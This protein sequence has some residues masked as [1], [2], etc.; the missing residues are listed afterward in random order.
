VDE[1]KIERTQS[2]GKEAPPGPGAYHLKYNFVERKGQG[3][4]FGKPSKDTKVIQDERLLLYPN[5]D[6][7]R[8]SHHPAKS[9]MKKPV[10]KKP[11]TP[12]KD[13]VA[14]K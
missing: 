11:K 10:H 8:P 13:V 5:I 4:S 1:T 14:P 7:A 3:Y 2:A 9:V 6:A 12:E